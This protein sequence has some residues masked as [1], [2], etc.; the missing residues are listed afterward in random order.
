LSISFAFRRLQSE[1][2]LLIAEQMKSI[3]ASKIY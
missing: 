3:S 2:S 1:G